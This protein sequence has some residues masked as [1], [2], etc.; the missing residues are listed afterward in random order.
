MSC[1]GRYIK[2]LRRKI[3]RIKNSSMY[4]IDDYIVIEEPTISPSKRKIKIAFEF[5]KIKSSKKNIYRKHVSSGKINNFKD[6]DN[7]FNPDLSIDINF[8]TNF[9]AGLRLKRKYLNEIGEIWS[10]RLIE[11]FPDKEYDLILY[12]DKISEDVFL[13]FYNGHIE[14]DDDRYKQVEYFLCTHRTSPG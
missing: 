7:Y 4:L 11:S 1:K 2:Y 10:K 3:N 13:D 9:A 8:T 14:L 6:F 5:A 12:F